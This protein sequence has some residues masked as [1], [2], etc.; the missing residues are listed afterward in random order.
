MPMNLGNPDEYTIEQFA[1]IIKELVGKLRSF[2]DEK[3]FFYLGS[4]AAL[5]YK[6]PVI[7]DPKQRRPDITLAKSWLNWAPHVNSLF[8]FY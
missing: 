1:L 7:D 5:E 3:K 2:C 4:K 6:D 8:F